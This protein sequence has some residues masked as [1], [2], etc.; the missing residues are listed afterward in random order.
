MAVHIQ[1]GGAARMARTIQKCMLSAIKL[2]TSRSQTFFE[3]LSR[4]VEAFI[5]SLRC[6][7]KQLFCVVKQDLEILRKLRLTVTE[8][9]PCIVHTI[10]FVKADASIYCS[11][12]RRGLTIV[13]RD[14]ALG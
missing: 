5:P 6:V 2:A 11:P 10:S 12:L 14:V 9:C 3:P 7:A 8:R 4:I 13:N 1:V